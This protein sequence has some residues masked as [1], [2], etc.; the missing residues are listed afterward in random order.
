M[1]EYYNF[2]EGLNSK[3]KLMT[4]DQL[5]KYEKDPNKDYYIS[6]YKYNEEQKKR[7]DQKGTIS[8]I[9][10][11]TTDILVWDFDSSTNPE[12]ARQDTVTLAHRL[13]NKYNVDPDS[14]QCYYSGSKGFHVVLYLGTKQV[15]PEEFKKATTT[16]AE[17]LKTFDVVVSDPAR[18][19]RME[20]TKHPKTGLFKIPL[21]ISEVDEMSMDNIK[22]LAKTSREDMEFSA[23]PVALPEVLFKAPEKKKEPAKE[24]EESTKPPKGWK[25][26]K[27]SIAQ[28]NFESGERHQALMVLAATCR[29]LGYDKEQ[30]YYMCKSALKKQARR[31]GQDEFPKEELWENIIEES[32][33]SDRWEGGQYSPKTNPW[34]A[35]YCER[36]GFKEDEKDEPA[37]VDLDI[38]T[39]QFSDYA[40]NFEQNIIKT[41][42]TELDENVMF[43]TS[44]LNGLLGQPGSGKT[45]MALNFL[46]NTSLNGIP[47]IFL[48]LDMGAPIVYAKLVQKATGYT[49]KKAL[50]LFR[51]N[52]QKAKEIANGIKHEYRNVGFNFKSGLTVSDIGQIISRHTETTGNKPRL[53]VIDYLECLAG[54]Y[55]DATANAALIANQ[56]KDL[57]NQ[58]EIS[59]LLLLQTQK[60][61]T[62]D[63][64]DPLLSMKQIKGSSVIEQACS[65]VVTLWREGYNPRFIDDDKYISFAVVKNRF[66]SLWQGDFSWEPIKG[67]IRSLSEE[68]REEFENFKERKKQQRANDAREMEEWGGR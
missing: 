41:G 2:K 27:W 18:V 61:S 4:L 37:C 50:E 1:Q 6:I 11:V 32:V 64:S 9:K 40:I 21:H 54:P 47:S 31:T 30:T 51:T 38:L 44:T 43:S 56:L 28:G 58:E 67:H 3:G 53:L 45:T 48:S 60:H 65:T 14:I 15:N 25:E 57:A 19:I 34:L 23:A 26:Y 8:G 17:G 33:F 22:D 68:E 52:P 10:D 5:S 62:P 12:L 63:I 42:I 49:F 55:S 24:M 39:N 13:V 29:A 66:G 20:Y 46:L 7:V 36:M 16:I 59:I 35:K